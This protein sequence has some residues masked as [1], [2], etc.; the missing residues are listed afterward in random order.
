[1]HL[2]V[3]VAAAVVALVTA[4]STPVFAQYVGGNPPSAGPNSNPGHNSSHH[5][6]GDTASVPV[7]VSGGSFEAQ[8][9]SGGLAVTGSDIVQLLLIGAACGG[10]GIV[11]IRRTRRRSVAA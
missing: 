5:L 10:V 9:T 1:M 8:D 11:M 3:A 4:F 2:R 6:G 7:R